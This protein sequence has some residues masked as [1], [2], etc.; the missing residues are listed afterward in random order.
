MKDRL[1]NFTAEE[2][3]VV[4]GTIDYV[5]VNQYTA[6]YV[7][8]RQPNATSPLSY[9]SN[10]HAEFVYKRNGVPIRSRENSDWLYI[11]PW[12]LYKAVTYVKEKYGNP[13]RPQCFMYENSKAQT[14]AEMNIRPSYSHP[15]S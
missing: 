3:D 9:S 8:D 5:G 10:W 11:M 7:R 1:P 4:R 14:T 15:C 13:T 12:G 6:Y 2:A